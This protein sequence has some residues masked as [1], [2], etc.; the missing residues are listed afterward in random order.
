MDSYTVIKDKSTENLLH[1]F[2][3]ECRDLRIKVILVYSPE[4]IEGQNFVTNRSEIINTFNDLAKDFNIFFLDYSNDAMCKD[5]NLFYNSMHL[6][7]KGAELFSKKL[8]T[9]LKY[10]SLFDSN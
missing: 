5:K 3:Q 4:Q 2:L 9:D 6:N 10:M 8:V 7:A 1:S